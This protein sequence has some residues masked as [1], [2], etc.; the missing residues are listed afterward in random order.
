MMSSAFC[1]VSRV[2]NVSTCTLGFRS[3]MRA[4]ADSSLGVPTADVPWR[5]CRCRLVLSTTSKSTSPSVPTPARADEQDAG[6]LELFLP[7]DAYVG[8][9]QVPRIAQDLFVRQLGPLVRHRPPRPSRDARDDGHRVA[10]AH[11]GL[12]VLEPPDVPVI[13]VDV[14]KA[15]QPAVR[16]KE[17]LLQGG[18]LAGQALQQLPDARA[19]ELERVAPIY[20]G[21]QRRGD[22]DFHC[23]TAFRSSI[24]MASSS[25]ARRSSA[26]TQLFSSPARPCA[27]ATMAYESH[28]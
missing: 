4:R 7:L 28:G 12:L 21:A 1:D 10:G 17:V 27:T 25:N 16:C 26:R 14:Y 5:I 15:A 6:G 22:Q 18:V 24:V 13:H 11:P 23:H 19:L 8:Q 20:I 9:D 2:S 3:W